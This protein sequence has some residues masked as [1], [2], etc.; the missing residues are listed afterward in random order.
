MSIAFNEKTFYEPHAK[1][2]ADTFLIWSFMKEAQHNWVIIEGIFFCRYS[3]YL[4]KNPSQTSKLLALYRTM[5][6]VNCCQ[7]VLMNCS[8]RVRD[9]I[10]IMNFISFKTNT[11][12]T[13]RMSQKNQKFY[14]FKNKYLK[15]F[16]N[17]NIHQL[18]ENPDLIKISS[19]PTWTVSNLLK[20]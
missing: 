7:Y 2:A 14:V 16:K 3:S 6:V 12:C 15:Q 11:I 10:I 9:I 4:K 8:T 17:H 19:T 18:C 5:I 13:Y 20:S 1:D